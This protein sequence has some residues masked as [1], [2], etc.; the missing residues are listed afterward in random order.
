LYLILEDGVYVANANGDA[1]TQITDNPAGT[2]LVDPER[3]SLYWSEAYG[4]WAMPLVTHPQNIIS[5]QQF[6]MITLVNEI[7]EVGR[8][9]I[10]Y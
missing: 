4:V 8:M 2:L 10:I 1:L 5:E 7:E 9:T 3:N 6:N